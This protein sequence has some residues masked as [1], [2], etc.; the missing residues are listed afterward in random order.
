MK[1]LLDTQALLWFLRNDSRLS[2]GARTAIE[3]PGHVKF[4]SVASG[5]EVAIKT[6]L[7]KLRL[8]LPFKELFPSHVEAQGFN[9]LPIEP[10]HLHPLIEMPHHHG[11]PFDR[12]LIAQALSEDMPLVSIDAAFDPYGVRRIW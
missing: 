1:L 7:G 4:V 2:L 10:R 6:S 5:W 12:L 9:I 11:D 8:P 3:D